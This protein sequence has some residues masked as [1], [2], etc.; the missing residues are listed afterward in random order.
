MPT[1]RTVLID[2]PHASTHWVGDG[3]PVRNLFGPGELAERLSPFLLLDYFG[4]HDFEPTEARRWMREMVRI[5]LADGRV[6]RAER[7]ILRSAAAHAG[8][9]THDTDQ[10]IRRTHTELYRE[11][12]AA[13]RAEKRARTQ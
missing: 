3:F 4:P 10:L 5:G 8:Y 6:S 9:S 7:R 13:L 1:P 11:S 2:R 12:R